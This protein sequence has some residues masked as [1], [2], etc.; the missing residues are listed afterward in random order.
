MEEDDKVDPA[1]E[2]LNEGAPPAPP[3]DYQKMFEAMQA[4]NAQLAQQN[5]QLAQTVQQVA[6]RPVVAQPVAAPVADPFADFE[7]TTAKALKGVI[8]TMNN[9]FK[10]QFQQQEQRFQHLTLEQEAAQIATMQGLTAD[11]IKRAQDIF[12]GN[13]AKGIPINAAECVDVVIGQDFR[14][15]KVNLGNQNRGAP[16]AL[17]GGARPP[18]PVKARPA[19]FDRMSRAEQIKHYESDDNL[20]N[21]PIAGFWEED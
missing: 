8:D 16:A 5:A 9:N 1:Q 15:G 18:A 12:R 10:Q 3:I 21:T 20:H 2:M 6:N 19:N 14:A 17:T 4:Q 13:R 11:Q 7:P